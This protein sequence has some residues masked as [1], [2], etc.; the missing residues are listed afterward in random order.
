MNKGRRREH[1]KDIS[2]IPLCLLTIILIWNSQL[3][4][5]PHFESY[6]LVI[7]QMVA[8][9]TSIIGSLS[10]LCHLDNIT[11]APKVPLPG[12]PPN[13]VPISIRLMLSYVYVK[14]T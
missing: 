7:A 4:S 14:G 9:S 11:T 5:R 3:Y 8:N 2:V 13:A 10:G 12:P 6:D 1:K